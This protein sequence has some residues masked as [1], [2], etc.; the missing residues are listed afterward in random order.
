M[1]KR[2]SGATTKQYEINNLIKGVSIQDAVF[3]LIDNSIDAAEKAKLQGVFKDFIID[4][5][6]DNKKFYI[7]DNCLGISRKEAGFC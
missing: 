5:N 6:I 4:I 1:K 7:R 3:Y 2:I